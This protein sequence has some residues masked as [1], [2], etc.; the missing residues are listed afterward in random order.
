ML[1]DRAITLYFLKNFFLP[2]PARPIKPVP[3]RSMVAGSGTGVTLPTIPK[4]NKMEHK[5]TKN[6]FI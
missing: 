4:T 2:S 6:F 5:N 1:S 3:S